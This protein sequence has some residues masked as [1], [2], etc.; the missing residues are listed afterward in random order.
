MLKKIIVMGRNAASKLDL[1][2][3]YAVISINDISDNTPIQRRWGLRGL[4]VL[5]FEDVAEDGSGSMK[6]E[7][8]D[9]VVDFVKGLSVE[10]LVVHC[11]AGVSRS[12]SM[13]FA[14]AENTI[15]AGRNAVEW[16]SKPWYA[17]Y[18]DM[19]NKLVY[20]LT[21]EAFGKVP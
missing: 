18:A 13:A 19:P 2:E 5:H 16:T 20:R 15:G 7:H 8:A 11:L 6:R 4:L 17:D 9:Q 21:S 14:I 3:P 10:T 12:P 1:D